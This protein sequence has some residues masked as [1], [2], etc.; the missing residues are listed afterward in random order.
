MNELDFLDNG[1]ANFPALARFCKAP[2]PM[3]ALNSHVAS[4]ELQEN[5]GAFK[6][7]QDV[8]NDTKFA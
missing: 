2:D 8:Q 7:S 5:L 4:L 6:F 3:M 1:L